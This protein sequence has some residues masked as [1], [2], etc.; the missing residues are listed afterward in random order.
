MPTFYNYRENGSTYSFDDVF[1]PT[2]AFRQG[3]LWT[4]GG[5]YY[6][7]LGNNTGITRSTPVTTFAGGVNWKQV[8]CGDTQSLAIK[9]DGTLWTW[10][11]ARY[12][13]LGVN[14]VSGSGRSTPVTTFAGG[15]NWKQVSSGYRHSAAIKTD[16]TLW[17][18][19]FNNSGQQGNNTT[20]TKPTP[21]TTF[22]GGTN[23]KQVDC[24]GY[25]TAAIKTDGTLWT[26]GNNTLGQLGDN[27][28]TQRN[29]PVTT[30]TGGTNWKQV[31]AGGFHTAAIKTDG[32]LWT[33]GNNGT[34]QLGLN[35][36]GDAF[37]QLDRSIPV[38]TFA[39]G[40]NWKQVACGNNYTAAIKTDGTLWTWGRNSYGALGINNTTQ[41]NT[42]VT[43]FAGGT[44]WKQVSAG[45][46]HTAAIK[47][48][49]TLWTWGSN[50]GKLGD[51]TGP[52]KL[53]PVT[54][55]AGGT[56]WKQT[57]SLAAITYIDDYQ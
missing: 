44:N 54:T 22:A 3:N 17:V 20:D 19:G 30:F 16:G 31:F 43:T 40:T 10:G 1:V 8:A 7:Q 57:A 50:Y 9:T 36:S 12:G 28:I 53:T 49:G 45:G 23:W 24:G 35:N 41:I 55:F 48:D 15:T 32:T 37:N 56:N 14:F 33:W 25:F 5:N 29:T 4:W 2:E 27:T 11:D 46:F 18:W 47:T 21:V 51:N 26:W 42:P 6:G 52:T 13:A 39:G 34:G 38:T